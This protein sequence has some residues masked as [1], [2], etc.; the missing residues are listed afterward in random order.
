MPQPHDSER[1]HPGVFF[2]VDALPEAFNT[3]GE[4]D[5]PGARLQ[6][7]LSGSS[8]PSSDA[9]SS[10]LEIGL[11]WLGVE[12]GHLAQIDLGSNRHTITTVAGTPSTVSQGDRLPL[13]ATYCRKVLGEN[14]VLTV[15]DAEAAGWAA[16]PAY[17][18]FSFSTYL[19]ATV[20]AE[21]ELY[22]ALCFGD[23]R[24][25]DVPLREDAAAV[26]KALADA[27]GEVLAR[28]GPSNRAL[29]PQNQ[30]EALFEHS[31]NMINLHDAAGNLIAPN[32]RLCEKTGYEP[33]EL[34]NMKVWELDQDA[35]P[36]E[37]RAAWA[38]MV[39]G[40]RRRWEG[41]FQRTDGSTFPVEVDVQCLEVEEGPRF[42]ATSRDI[43]ERRAAQTALEQREELHRETL[44]N[45]T[46]AVFITR[47]D[48]TFTYV[49]PNVEYIFKQSREEVEALGSISALLGSDPAEQQDFGKTQEVQNIEHRVVDAEGTEHDLLIN[50]R[51][52]SIQE[53]CRM[54]TCR[55]VT[56]RKDAERE[57]KKQNDLL[58]EI[59]HLA[60][61]GGWEYDVQTEEHTWTQEVY[62][63]YGLSEDVDPTVEGGISYYHPEDQS[64]IRAAFTR[65]VEEGEPYE[66]ELRLLRED[67]EQRWV[68]T[69]GMPQVSDG[70]VVQVRG[71][72]QDI[73]ERKTAEQ[74]LRNTKQLLEKTFENLGEVVLIVDPPNR[75]IISCNSAVEDVFGYKKEELIGESTEKLH[76]SPEAYQ[77]FGKIGE[78]ILEEDGI[79]RHEYQMRRKNGE[80]IDTEHVVTPL[81]DENWPGGVVSVIRD[82]TEQ[83]ETRRQLREERDLLDRILETSPAAIAVL[84][85]DGAFIEASARAEDILG[86][87][88]E[89]VTERTYDDPEWNI[90]RPDGTP[91][92]EAELPFAR[93]MDTDA[94][95]YDVEHKIE[96]PDGTQRLLSVSGAPLHSPDGD[97]EGAVFHMDDITERRAAKRKLRE[98]RDRFATLFHN[99]PT[100]VVHGRRDDEDRIHIQAVNE[101]FETVFGYEESV[102]RSEGWQDLLVPDSEQDEAASIRRSLL[103]GTPVQ[104]EVR[105]QTAGEVRD[106]RVQVALRETDEQPTEGFAIYTD[107]TER[108]KQQRRREE[109]IR[110]VTDAIVEIDA[111]WRFT[112]LNDQAEALYEM[113]E[114]ALL[115]KRFW[116]IFP[117]AIGTRFEEVYRGVMTTR[118]PASIEEYYP[119]LNGWFN[120]Q[121]YPNPDGGIAFYFQDITERKKQKQQLM[122]RKALLEAQARAT[123]DGLLVID[124]DRHVM[125][126]NDQFLNLWDIPKEVADT[127]PDEHLSESTLLNSA[128]HLLANPKEFRRKVEYLYNH[129]DKESRDLIQLTDGRWFDRYSAPIRSDDG[130]HFGRLWIF[131]DVTDQRRMLERLLEVQEEERR[132]IDQEIHDEMGGLLTSLQFTID[133]ARRETQEHGAPSTHFDQLEELVSDLSTVSRTI[134]RKLYPSDLSNSGLVEAVSSLV[135]K[136]KEKHALEI[137]FY[138]EFAH[139]ERFSKII[140]RTAFWI[141]Q[142]VLVTIAGHDATDAA[143]V[144]LTKSADQLHLHIFDDGVEV[145]SSPTGEAPFGLDNIRSRVERLNGDIDIAPIPD[146][147]TRISVTL[148]AKLPFPAQ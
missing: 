32:P 22:G 59:Q 21:G 45:I 47:S 115:G 18:T 54:Y 127:S 100:P 119:G 19:G 17:E 101:R 133:I 128:G 103:E 55:D 146:E 9:L 64:T 1:S 89:K 70:E 3:N 25:Q 135:N 16:D 134:S 104:H 139:G 28:S 113:P 62:R 145:G 136:L 46:D 71:S 26:V 69:R 23:R 34:T 31:P 92:P 143:H 130:T 95:V 132:R 42:V 2:S 39:P 44:R 90:R 5:T 4:N 38:E 109:V 57:L 141:A 36:E 40:D 84:N 87:T 147:G 125:F 123:I 12:H 82:V 124:P 94:P 122:R 65:A 60:N 83:K 137:D 67:G 110:R 63:I 52:V 56:G 99:L 148:P 24:P 41:T 10:I 11:D 43:S 91:M 61:V 108:K 13:S 49:C 53:G 117:E 144:T 7:L 74:D 20:V 79:F 29:P 114:E 138:S 48:G 68:R 8:S 118:E 120:I 50:I 121:V 73:T 33:E 80:I 126:Y 142:E 85:T 35:D 86:L 14:A 76:K 58:S 107:I 106:F 129:P 72:I 37:A 97:L 96:W 105:R 111:D 98:E 66:L 116:D 140:E 15:N 131:R 77:R 78:P 93:V 102:I 51:R 81:E 75:R 6:S 112:L 30:L 27:A 88:K